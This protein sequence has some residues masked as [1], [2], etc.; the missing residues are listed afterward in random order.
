MGDR[1]GFW[2]S[3]LMA[4]G[5]ADPVDIVRALCVGECRVHGFDV[6]TAIGHLGMTR[7]AGGRGIFI[8]TGMASPAADA[9]MDAD[10]RAIVSRRKLRTPMIRGGDCA[11]FWNS[12]RMALVAESLTLIRT[13]LD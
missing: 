13:H 10:W 3:V 6:D 2:H 1:L 5:A 8:V 11:G 7:L 4:V 12:R 9:L